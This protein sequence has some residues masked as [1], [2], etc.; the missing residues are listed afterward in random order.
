MPK[1]PH[2]HSKS[3]CSKHD[4][5]SIALYQQDLNLIIQI[6]SLRRTLP[7]LFFFFFF[8]CRV[9]G[10]EG[11]NKLK[12]YPTNNWIIP[13]GIQLTSQILVFFQVARRQFIRQYF[14]CERLTIENFQ[15]IEV[16]STPNCWTINYHILIFCPI[17]YLAYSAQMVLLA[18]QSLQSQR[19]LQLLN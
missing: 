10:Q 6:I 5:N 11:E 4:E 8:L 18:K 19:L 13:Q 9:G 12:L 7:F 16:H 1:N 15:Y 3:L 14:A 2:N 17:D